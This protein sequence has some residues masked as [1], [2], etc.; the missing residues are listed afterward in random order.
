MRDLGWDAH[1]TAA[2][3]MP[4]KRYSLVSMRDLSCIER[5]S[6]K[7]AEMGIITG[8]WHHYG[9][10]RRLADIFAQLQ[11]QGLM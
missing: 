7:V 1:I 2:S 6:S 4:E 9:R 3:T 10:D 11:A 8:G 5:F